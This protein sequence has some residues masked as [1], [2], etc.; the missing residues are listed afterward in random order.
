MISYTA[1]YNILTTREIKS[2]KKHK[3]R[4]NHRRRKKEKNM[5]ANWFRQ[6]EHYLIGFKTVINILFM[7]LLMMQPAAANIRSLYV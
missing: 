1:L 6:T 5:K 2:K 4:E 7:V 3:R